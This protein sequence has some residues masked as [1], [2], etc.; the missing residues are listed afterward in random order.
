MKKP[1]ATFAASVLFGHSLVSVA[2][3][4]CVSASDRAALRTAAVQQELMVAALQCHAVNEYNRFVLSHQPEL[5]S[6]DHALEA[7]FQR[8]DKARGTATYNKYKTELANGASLR[9]SQDP[10]AFCD[11]AGRAFD[12]ALEPLSLREIVASVDL[13]SGR[14]GEYCPVLADNGPTVAVAPPPAAR[15][16]RADSDLPYPHRASSARAWDSGERDA[17]FEQSLDS[18]ARR[19][20]A[21]PPFD[22]AHDDDDPDE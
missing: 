11:A 1:L 21:T 17:D 10:D 12:I 19:D 2:W 5:I 14:A 18:Q 4:E 15:P 6:S 3:A 7:Y 20:D 16:S 13:K 8:G 9:S 22:W